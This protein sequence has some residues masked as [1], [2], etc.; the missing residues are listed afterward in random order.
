M[1]GDRPAVSVIVV[2]DYGGRTAEDWDYLRAAFRGLGQQAFDEPFE[3][4]LAD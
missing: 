4:L 3:V 1:N 2:S